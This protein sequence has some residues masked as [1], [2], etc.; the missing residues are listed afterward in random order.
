MRLHRFNVKATFVRGKDMV[1]PDTLSG[2]LLDHE[3][4]ETLED[5]IK[6]Y[7]EAVEKHR[8]ISD[9]KL[10]QILNATERDR[11]LQRVRKSIMQGWLDRDNSI[12]DEIKPYYAVRK[13]HSGSNGMVIYQSRVVIPMAMQTE[14]LQSIHE[15]H[16]GINKRRERAR[17]C[18]WWPTISKISKL[19]LKT[20][21][22]VKFISQV[23]EKSLCDVQICLNAFGRKSLPTCANMK[24]GTVS[25]SLT[26]TRVSLK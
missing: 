22:F 7:V 18:V 24:V 19:W 20:V 9:K 25:L 15:G 26:I 1:V 14:T 8:P 6:F 21:N 23:R 3:Q 2:A 10:E 16:M 5:D 4:N 13:E 11:D 17:L 12:P